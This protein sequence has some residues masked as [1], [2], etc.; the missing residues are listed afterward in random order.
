MYECDDRFISEYREKLLHA[1]REVATSLVTEEMDVDSVIELVGAKARDRFVSASQLMMLT[2]IVL[3]DEDDV[4]APVYFADGLIPLKEIYEIAMTALDPV[5]KA[6][7]VYSGLGSKAGYV[8]IYKN[9]SDDRCVAVYSS[10]KNVPHK[11]LFNDMEMTL[12]DSFY[13]DYALFVLGGLEQYEISISG[14]TSS[15]ICMKSLVT[16]KD[17]LTRKLKQLAIDNLV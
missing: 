14:R 11:E 15:K 5:G 13:H 3:K 7:L 4:L 10:K 2:E 12:V 16:S 8:N 9:V 6:H 1:A 17:V